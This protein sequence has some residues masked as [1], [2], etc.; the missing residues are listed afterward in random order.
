[1][2]PLAAGCS[3][4]ADPGIGSDQNEDSGPGPSPTGTTSAGGGNAPVE[5]GGG[6]ASHDDAGGGSVGSH[7]S[8]STPTPTDAGQPPPTPPSDAGQPPP[9][10]PDAGGGGTG[11][12]GPPTRQTCTGSFG[13]GLSTSHARLDGYVVAVI[14]PGQ[15][16]SCNGDSTHVHL[17]ISMNNAIYDVAAN[18]DGLE[19]EK[20]TALLGGAWSEGWHTS[21]SLDYPGDLG[22]HSSDFSLTGVSAVA[23]EVEQQLAN[24]NHVSVF[25]TG[26][27]AT[28]CHLVHRQGTGK[29]GAIVIDPLSPTSHWLLFDFST[30][31]F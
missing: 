23:A 2:V 26:Y 13:S 1:V 24:A 19:T 11:T 8:G 7:D 25:C 16:K 6:A 5:A 17:Q 10:P 27:D 9:P 28:G 12:D 21:D 22:V 30:D 29:D 4:A 3:G 18:A 14:P 20:D 15:G 31:N